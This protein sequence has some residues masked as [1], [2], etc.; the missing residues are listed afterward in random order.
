MELLRVGVIGCGAISAKY[1]E[2][3]TQR[4]RHC[5]DVRACADLMP[6]RATARAEEFGVP[7]ACPPDDVLA[8]PAIELV[9]NLTV[10]AA[11]YAVSKAALEAGK[12]VYTEKPLAVTRAEGQ[13]LLARA[14]A[15]GLRLG[16]APDTFLGA[17][18]QTCRKLIDEGWIG[19]P[20]AATALIA[21]GVKSQRYHTVGIGPMFDMGPYFI[22]ALVA[23]LGPV[24]RVTG[25]AQTPFATKSVEDPASPEWGQPF[26]VETP[27]NISAVLDMASGPVAT[28]TTTCDIFGYTPRLEFYG[29]EGILIANDP[30]MF[31]KPV[32]LR[33]REGDFREMPFT[34]GY[35]ENS[36]GL[37]VADMAYAIRHGRPHRASAEL[38]YHTLDVMHATHESSRE[39]RHVAVQSRVERP[40]PLPA[41]L[42]GNPLA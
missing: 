31:S 25:S 6:E 29:S 7:V 8:D 34:H 36:R 28:L 37:G 4:F 10:P 15:R 40:V 27:T 2:N 38:I 16:G 30:N 1:L 14:A 3:M 39:G 24:A 20:V 5:L 35:A 11:H 41:G 21:M 23:L 26:A 32:L 12:H 9:V 42:G 17:G 18:L 13:D 22:T 19:Q 33:R